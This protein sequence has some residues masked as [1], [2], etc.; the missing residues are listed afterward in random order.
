MLVEASLRFFH[1]VILVQEATSFQFVPY[2][3]FF[4][5]YKRV[6]YKNYGRLRRIY[7]SSLRLS[8]I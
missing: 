6:I 3:D 5:K 8:D 4:H 2:L 1:T 7:L